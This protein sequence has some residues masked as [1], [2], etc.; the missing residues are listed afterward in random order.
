MMTETTAVTAADGRTLDLYVARPEDQPRGGV[1]V[2]QEIFGVNHH[3]RAVAAGF[4][5][6]GYLAV[7]PALFDR[8]ERGVEMDY[9]PA[10]I[11]RGQQLAMQVAR[12]ALKD[13]AA[14]LDFVRNET[15]RAGAVVGYCFGGTLAW[16]AATRLGPAAV[17]SYYGGMIGDYVQEAP[18]CSVLMH[19]GERDPHIP[20]ESVDRIRQAH[21]EV[22]VHTYPAGHGFNC[23]ERAA[24]DPASAALARERTLA[25]LREK[26]GQPVDMVRQAGDGASAERQPA[27]VRD[28]A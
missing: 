7:A 8:A 12:D 28:R 23:T 5:A 19:F 16:L 10:S 25:F 27:S 1:V 18:C 26:L 13:V 11:E 17:V 22:A 9:S 2:I 14:A 4:G 15:G 6:K 24:Y 21:P 20:P 3:I